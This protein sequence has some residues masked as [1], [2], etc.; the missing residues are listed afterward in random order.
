MLYYSLSNGFQ[1]KPTQGSYSFDI[2]NYQTILCIYNYDKPLQ[3]INIDSNDFKNIYES[4]FKKFNH[5]NIL[6]NIIINKSI[7]NI[8][9]YYIE[10][11]QVYH[12][13][14]KFLNI[15]TL[16]KIKYIYNMDSIII[17]S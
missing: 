12:P 6:D 11:T 3:I 16:Y 4:Y 14:Y 9:Q 2:N 5:E 1:L 7:K 13:D 10:E 8:S 15:Y 17:Q